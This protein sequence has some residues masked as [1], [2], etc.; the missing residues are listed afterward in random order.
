MA[1]PFLC[2][3][4]KVSK[5]SL[6]HWNLLH[7]GNIQLKIK[8]LLSEINS[9]QCASPDPDLQAREEG[10]QHALQEELLHEESLWKQKSRDLW[11]SSSDLNTKFFHA[12]T[13]IRRRSNTI[14]SIT[15]DNGSFLINRMDVG[16]HFAAYFNNLYS[17]SHPVLD[18]KLSSLFSPVISDAENSALCCIPEEAEIRSAIAQL[19]L[20]KAPGPDGFAGLFF[21]TYWKTICISVINFVQ[22]FFRHGFLWKELNHSHIALIPKVE[23]PSNVS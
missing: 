20:T 10:L 16:S 8:S 22:S 6:K 23:N 1:C 15:L 13:A 3:K 12:S 14:S 18:D 2:K 5:A 9:I 4:F 7:F 19:G 21:K 17:S 11:L